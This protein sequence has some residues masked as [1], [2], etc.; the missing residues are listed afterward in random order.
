MTLKLRILR[1]LTRLFIILVRLTRSLFIEKMLIFNRCISGLMTNLIKKSYTDSNQN[2]RRKQNVSNLN[3]N[4]LSFYYSK[5]ILFPSKLLDQNVL[6]GL[7]KVK[8]NSKKLFLTRLVWNN[9]DRSKRI[10]TSPNDFGHN[11]WCT[12]FRSRYSIVTIV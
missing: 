9:L 3:Y 4:A 12:L 10:W 2:A 8:F 5:T 6:E 7:Q 11:V 1:S